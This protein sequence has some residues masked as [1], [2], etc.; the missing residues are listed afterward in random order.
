MNV[1]YAYLNRMAGKGRRMWLTS[2]SV[3]Y[4]IKGGHLNKYYLTESFILRKEYFIQTFYF[5]R[6]SHSVRFL[7]TTFFKQ[8]SSFYIFLTHFAEN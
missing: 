3:L 1:F 7:N 4:T 6:A 8:K 2:V 5:K